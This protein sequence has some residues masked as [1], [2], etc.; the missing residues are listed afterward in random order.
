[1]SLSTMCSQ[2]AW[3]YA[4]D[5]MSDFSPLVVASDL[6]GPSR[7]HVQPRHLQRDLTTTGIKHTM[8]MLTN[9]EREHAA[10]NRHTADPV[11]N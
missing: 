1:M 4:L 2:R 10:T 8:S 6:K 3:T 11:E 9:E 7:P 5:S